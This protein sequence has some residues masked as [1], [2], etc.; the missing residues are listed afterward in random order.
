MVC[1]STNNHLTSTVFIVNL[2]CANIKRI[3][4]QANDLAS[5]LGYDDTA[6][7]PRVVK[8]HTSDIRMYFRNTVFN[9]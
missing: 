6:R 3:R 8:F 9:E 7:I 2:L 5:V 1:I 4:V